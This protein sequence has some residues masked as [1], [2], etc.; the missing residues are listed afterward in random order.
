MN[1]DAHNSKP[2]S[3]ST[4]R[5]FDAYHRINYLYQAAHLIASQKPQNIDMASSYIHVL[6]SVRNR[7]VLKI[8]P[9]MKRTF[10][11]KCS[12][13]LIPGL[14]SS[15]RVKSKGKKKKYTVIK[16]LKCNTVKRYSHNSNHQLWQDKP[17]A[18]NSMASVTDC[19]G[20]AD[21]IPQP[22]SSGPPSSMEK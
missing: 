4:S 14:T 13:L 17:E 11:K 8:D 20:K 2:S 19:R 12:S 16:C 21:D 18:D 10:C 5:G 15:V 1:F 6:K 9:H 7:R 3:T 22:E